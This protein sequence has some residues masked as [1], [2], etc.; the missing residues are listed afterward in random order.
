MVGASFIVLGHANGSVANAAGRQ[1]HVLSGPHP[2]VLSIPGIVGESTQAGH[3]GGIDILSFSWGASN[4]SSPLRNSGGAG[5]VSFTNIT[6]S[7]VIDRASPAL[8]QACASRTL[9]RTA[10][11]YILQNAGTGD[12]AKITLTNAYVSSCNQSG[13]SGGGDAESISMN[14]AKISYDYTPQGAAILHMG[15]DLKKNVKA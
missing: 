6:F 7:K 11:F 5:K 10:T 4:T 12:S 15:W 1:P 2:E 3:P 9:F 8:F 13:S 14:F